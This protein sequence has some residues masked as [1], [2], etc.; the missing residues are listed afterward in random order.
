VGSSRV[1][2]RKTRDASGNSR[3]SNN[4]PKARGLGEKGNFKKRKRNMGQ[5]APEGEIGWEEGGGGL[6]IHG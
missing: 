5:V 1:L 3:K 6:K 2:G 4:G